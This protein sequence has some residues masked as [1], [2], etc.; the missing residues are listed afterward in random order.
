MSGHFTGER[1]SGFAELGLDKR[2]PG[3]TDDGDAALFTDPVDKLSRAFDVI[4]NLCSR[5][6]AKNVFCEK[7]HETIGINHFAFVCHDAETIAVAVKREAVV[8]ADFLHLAD[9][10][11]KVFRFGR[12]RMVIREMS[13]HVAVEGN[14]FN[15]ELR[16]DAKHDGPCNS[17]AGVNHNL[18]STGKS[19][20]VN[21]LF[22]I[23]R[24]GINTFDRAW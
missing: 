22:N 7:H 13:V 15:V 10:H 20:A 16:K 8:C 14:N 11:F 2:M 19:N 5:M 3:W 1:R 17:V 12:I 24:N 18:K 6:R 21:H 9:Q 4:D 23:R